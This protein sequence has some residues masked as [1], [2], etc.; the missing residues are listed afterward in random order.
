MAKKPS[1]R[2]PAKPGRA[3]GKNAG[4]G[5]SKKTRSPMPSTQENKAASGKQI[6]RPR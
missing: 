4:S 5:G 6:N 2:R 1:R 3:K